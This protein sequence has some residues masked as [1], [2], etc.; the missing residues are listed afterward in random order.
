MSNKH[1]TSSDE[2]SSDQEVTKPAPA[3]ARK[4]TSMS[5]TSS[6]SDIR[7]PTTRRQAA[8]ASKERNAKVLVDAEKFMENFDPERSLRERRKLT[9]KINSNIRRP[10]GALYDEVGCHIA[11]GIDLCD[12]LNKDC[13]G[14]HF[15]CPKCKSTKCGSDCRVNRKYMYEQIEY[16][17]SDIIIKNPLAKT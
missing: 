1:L 8:I 17:G 11:T 5:S 7:Q 10:A 4:S 3:V 15:P 2:E 12:C 14:C 6:M 9:R 16:Q 13:I